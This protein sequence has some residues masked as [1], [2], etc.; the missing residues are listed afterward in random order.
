MVNADRKPLCRRTQA[1]EARPNIAHGE[2][3]GQRAN[4][5]K[6]RSAEGWTW[7]GAR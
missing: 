4:E 3:V 5:F 2:A 7:S 6:Y 1:P